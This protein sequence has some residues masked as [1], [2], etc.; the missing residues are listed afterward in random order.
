[1]IS[2]ILLDFF[3]PMGVPLLLPISSR[4][5]HI[6]GVSESCGIVLVLYFLS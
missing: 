5:F 2:H 3:N 4:K 1:M 6:L